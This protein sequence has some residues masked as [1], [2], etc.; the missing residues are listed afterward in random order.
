MIIINNRAM[1]HNRIQE[2]DNKMQ[3]DKCYIIKLTL[4]A[5]HD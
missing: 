4:I 5:C 3:N 2:N 1:K